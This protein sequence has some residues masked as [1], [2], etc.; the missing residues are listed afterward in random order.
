MKFLSGRVEHTLDEKK[1]F[2]IPTKFKNAFPPEEAIHYVL[3][4][5]GCITLMCDSVLNRRMASLDTADP[6][7]EEAMD[8][9]RRILSSID[10]YTEDSYGRASVPKFFLKAANIDKDIVSIGMGDYVEIWAAEE[11]AAKE[12]AMS[13][14]DANRIAYR[15]NSEN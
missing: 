7:D 12:G 5:P 13:L 6:G 15:K 10:D 1:R 8:A 9:K 14:R 11:F 2:R 4:A 3:Y